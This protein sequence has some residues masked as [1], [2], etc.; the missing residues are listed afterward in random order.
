[1]YD[2]LIQAILNIVVIKIRVDHKI[3]S[4]L[5]VCTDLKKQLG[6]MRKIKFRKQRTHCRN[7][8]RE[9][10]SLHQ[11]QSKKR[12]KHKVMNSTKKKIK[13]KRND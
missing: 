1:M 9:N 13:S 12:Q 2:N 8:R 4:Y 5:H 10:T 11:S 3:N 7:S 6:R